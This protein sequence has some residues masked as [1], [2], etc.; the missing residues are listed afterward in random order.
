[1]SMSYV[2]PV[3]RENTYRRVARPWIRHQ[4]K[5]YGGELIEVRGAKSIFEAQEQG[6]QQAKNRYIF[7][8]HDDV[9]LVTPINLLTH[10]AKAF[11]DNKTVALIGP[12]GKIEKLVVPWWVNRGLYVGHWC[13]RGRNHQLVYQQ[14]N[15]RGGVPFSNV[16]GDPF[17]HWCKTRPR[18]DRFAK[19]GLVDGFYLIEDS[20][21]FSTPWD[22]ETYR[23]QWHCYDVDRC[24]Q[25]HEA[26][27]EIIV[28]PWLFLHDNAGHAGYKGTN[29]ATMHGADQA[30]RRIN[31]AGDKLWLADLD[32]TNKLVREKWSIG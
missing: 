12:A 24:F 2:V 1:M 11:D 32:A 6:R 19:A 15:N 7:Y 25:V 3:W 18:W 31:S 10:V 27:L 23:D 4:V 26:G 17:S 21:R 13:R 8:C 5:H 30:N 22:T 28:P 16:I 9:K 14:A 29:P 20:K